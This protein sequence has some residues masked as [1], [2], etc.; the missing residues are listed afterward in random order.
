MESERIQIGASLVVA[1]DEGDVRDEVIRVIGG[2]A[3]LGL[4]LVEAR[5]NGPVVVIGGHAD[6]PPYDLAERL[7]LPTEEWAVS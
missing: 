1:T 2:S 5:H 6:A 3:E 4:W 7:L